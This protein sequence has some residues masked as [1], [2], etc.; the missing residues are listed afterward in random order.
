MVKALQGE[1]ASLEEQLEAVSSH[2][3]VWEMERS[4]MAD[5]MAD[6]LSV[7]HAMQ[8]DR[9]KLAQQL[10]SVRHASTC[11]HPRLSA[12]MVNAFSKSRML[13]DNAGICPQECGLAKHATKHV[14]TSG[15][16]MR[17][18]HASRSDRICMHD[19][20]VG[21][22]QSCPKHVSPA[23]ELEFGLQPQTYVVHAA[24]DAAGHLWRCRSIKPRHSARRPPHW[25]SC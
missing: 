21:C 13:T 2:G 1:V 25:H 22:E 16:S 12:L 18:G 4:T 10:Y 19:L 7:A 9:D 20:L 11:H 3:T 8:A 24:A 23:H 6:Q 15:C 14:G 5:D 17:Q